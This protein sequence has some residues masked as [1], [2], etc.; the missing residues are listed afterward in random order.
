MN[1][2]PLCL[3]CRHFRDVL[4][5]A[6]YS[7]VDFWTGLML[8]LMGG[9]LLYQPFLFTEYFVNVYSPI[10]HLFTQQVWAL[11]FMTFGLYAL[12]VVLWPQRPH[13]MVRLFARMG[14]SFCFLAL[15][16]NHLSYPVPPLGV[17]VYITL[18]MMCVV[19]IL[20]T[21]CHVR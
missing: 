7:N 18:S 6:P 9:Y 13:F 15:A 19:S 3:T 8:V 20:R 1:L 12:A 11:Q 2:T 21:K 17:I 10:V 5:R 4:F 14:T 16:M